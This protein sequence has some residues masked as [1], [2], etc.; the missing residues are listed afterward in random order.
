M[1]EKF[2]TMVSL[3]SH[4]A[5]KCQIA[6]NYYLLNGGKDMD[7]FKD[8]LFSHDKNVLPEGTHFFDWQLTDSD[9]LVWCFNNRFEGIFQQQN[10]KVYPKDRSVIDKLSGVRFHHSFTRHNDRV[11]AETIPLEYDEARLKT[12]YLA[13]KFRRLLDV[14]KPIL[15][16]MATPEGAEDVARVADAL[17]AAAGPGQTPHLLAVCTKGPQ[18]HVVAETPH[19]TMFSIPPDKNRPIEEEWMG[20]DIYWQ[21]LL[22]LFPR[23]PAPLVL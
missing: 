19:Y 6:L 13:D 9:A 12:L 21:T 5:T 10:L 2:A 1:T 23:D 7:A 3:G 20:N 16:V 14:P 17:V 15:Y 4:C 8:A 11:L 18:P 22:S